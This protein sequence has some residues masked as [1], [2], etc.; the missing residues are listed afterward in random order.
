MGWRGVK[1]FTIASPQTIPAGFEL[2]YFELEPGG[3]SSLEKH[4]H[5]HFVLALRGAGRALVGDEVYELAPLDAIYVAPLT[6][7]RW[8]NA[9]EE[10]FGF[11]CP[12]DGDRDSPIPL[13]E[14][15][16]DSLRRQPADRAL[17][18]LRVGAPSGRVCARSGPVS[19]GRGRTVN[20]GA[21]PS[22]P[23]SA[24]ARSSSAI[25]GPR[26]SAQGRSRRARISSARATKRDV[27]W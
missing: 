3:Y 18:L 15:E 11:L 27:W 6:P 2:R 17:R 20:F 23:P 22:P 10:P 14:A 26:R 7:H 9:S 1:R 19:I 13:D 5:V 24:V 25:T 8:I 4:R 16:W 21:S 12:V